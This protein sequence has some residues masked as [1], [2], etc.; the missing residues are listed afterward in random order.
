MTVV[1]L[2]LKDSADVLEIDTNDIPENP[3]EL[4]YI[5]TQEDAAPKFYVLFAV[6]TI[7]IKL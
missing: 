2:P 5:L 4:I 7:I 3:E 1:E 6:T